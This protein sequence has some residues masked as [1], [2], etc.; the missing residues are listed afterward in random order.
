MKDKNF[1]YT[2]DDKKIKRMFEEMGLPTEDSRMHYMNSFCMKFDY[3]DNPLKTIVSNNSNIEG[4]AE[5]K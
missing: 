1:K 4:Y 3:T 5:F 2:L